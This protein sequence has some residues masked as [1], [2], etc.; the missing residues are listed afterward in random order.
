MVIT[1][2]ERERNDRWAPHSS[3]LAY[4]WNRQETESQFVRGHRF[5]WDVVC[6]SFLLRRRS[7]RIS[8]DYAERWSMGGIR[9]SC[10]D[11]TM[12]L[13]RRL[14]PTC[15]TSNAWVHGVVSNVY[16]YRGTRTK[17]NERVWRPWTRRGIDAYTHV[18]SMSCSRFR[19]WSRRKTREIQ[20]RSPPSRSRR[21]WMD[22]GV[23]RMWN[24]N[25]RPIGVH[26][27]KMQD[28]FVL[29]R[30]GIHPGNEFFSN[31]NPEIWL[32]TSR[33]TISSKVFRCVISI[34]VEAIGYPSKMVVL[35]SLLFHSSLE[36][37]RLL[38]E[39]IEHEKKV[40]VIFLISPMSVISSKMLGMWA[41]SRKGAID[42]ALNHRDEP[43]CKKFIK[44]QSQG[45]CLNVTRC[46]CLEEV[47][48]QE[49]M[50]SNLT[51]T[52]L[53]SIQSE[54]KRLGL[55]IFS[56]HLVCVCTP[57]HIHHVFVV[58]RQDD[59]RDKPTSDLFH[60]AFE[61]VEKDSGVVI[62]SLSHV[63]IRGVFF[64]RNENL[65]SLMQMCSFII[66]ND[67]RKEKKKTTRKQGN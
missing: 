50:Q 17:G 44:C 15:P 34:S 4:P 8:D 33:A 66:V 67:E 38:F 10:G 9:V 27:T 51:L 11:P 36:L 62:Y 19:Y 6:K 60:Q 1:S 32:R 14:R 57:A 58:G 12:V 25:F 45:D 24:E 55:L 46:I 29:V 42:S 37:E 48:Y 21:R 64:R 41:T 26:E 59:C 35:F 5:E 65:L 28:L 20:S 53:D 47:K 49:R 22:V 56:P 3:S 61:G 18:L 13:V 54:R 39:M 31:R 52:H 40:G 43:K 23:C 2:S 63:L 7:G 16:E 30:C